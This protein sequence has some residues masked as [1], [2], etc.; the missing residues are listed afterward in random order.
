MKKSA[1]LFFSVL[2]SGVTSGAMAH[3]GHGVTA[4][5]SI[6][7]YLLEPLHIL[8]AFAPLAAVAVTVWLLR[9]RAG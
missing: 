9:R 2:A 6:L 4:P 7:H 3:G 1:I 5:A 8:P